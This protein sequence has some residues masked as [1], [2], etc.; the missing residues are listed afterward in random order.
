MA[1]KLL[2]YF[3]AAVMLLPSGSDIARAAMLPGEFSQ[4]P[5]ANEEN[6]DEGKEVYLDA[7][8]EVAL[9]EGVDSAEA[10]ADSITPDSAD[11]PL[12]VVEDPT[13]SYILAGK[14][15]FNPDPTRAG[16]LSALFP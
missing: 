15:E 9:P 14:K 7:K 10:A 12:T 2:K 13:S 11:G 6:K 8:V 3:L 16:W 5:E 4:A 1:E